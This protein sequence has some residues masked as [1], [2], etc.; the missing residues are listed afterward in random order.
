MPKTLRST[1]ASSFAF[2]AAFTAAAICGPAGAGSA[3][4]GPMPTVSV[5]ATGLD[6]PRGLK[7]G[8][9]GNL[10]VA[11]AGPGGSNSTDGQC[12]QVVPAVGPYT[13]ANTGGRISM[14]DPEGNVSTVI[15]TLPSSQTSAALGYLRSGVA[16]VAFIGNTLYAILSGAGCSHGVTSLPNG[17]VRI[18]PDHSATLIADLSAYQQSHPTAVTEDEDFEPD[19]TW[20]SMV[21]VRG[22]LYAV[23]P[24]HGEIDRITP[25]GGITRV[26]DV[27]AHEGHIVPTA[28]AYHGNFYVGNLSTFPQAIGSAKVWKVNPGGAIQQDESGFNMILGLAFDGND[29]MYVLEM[30][31]E[32]PA[33]A[34]FSGR[35]TRMEPNGTR[36]IIADHLMFPTAMTM[37]PDGNLYV[38][39]FGL[40]TPPGSGQVLKI[41]LEHWQH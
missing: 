4:A 3:I 29:R 37:G 23:E 31:A 32:H 28:I 9:D 13:G 26:I 12:T 39:A 19:G 7:F 8:P 6:N 5:F 25:A 18:N 41:D 11:E 27:S 34:P 30:A 35:V 36:K 10:Y 40:G 14:I 33:P 15:D 20:Y 2:Y 24:N 1:F 21:A 16:D 17:V 38:S 22:S